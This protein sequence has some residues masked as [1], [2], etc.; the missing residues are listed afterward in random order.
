MFQRMVLGQLDAAAAAKSLQSC[1]TLCDSP[2]SHKE[3]D[4]TERIYEIKQQNNNDSQLPA[5]GCLR[6]SFIK[7]GTL[8]KE[9]L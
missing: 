1:P 2:W 8:K 7:I 4:M 3:L 6:T 5:I 9:M